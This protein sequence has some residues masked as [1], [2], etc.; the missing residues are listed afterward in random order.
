MDLLPTIIGA[1]V[2]I[3]LGFVSWLLFSI[4][5]EIA[6]LKRQQQ[7]VNQGA[8]ST[9]AAHVEEIRGAAPV[10]AETMAIISQHLELA[11]GEIHRHHS[12]N[13]S[14]Q[15]EIAQRLEAGLGQLQTSLGDILR[16][17][18]RDVS[19]GIV[20]ASEKSTDDRNKSRDALLVQLEAVRSEVEKLRQEIRETVTFT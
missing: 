16:T 4:R 3:E 19:T 13:G 9:M 10:I 8:L 11:R 20:S 1:C 12:E 2:I 14:Q 6:S 7:E 15:S 17:F 5:K 18:H